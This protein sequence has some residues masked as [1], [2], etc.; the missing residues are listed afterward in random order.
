MEHIRAHQRVQRSVEQARR[1]DWCSQLPPLLHA[2][3]RSHHLS[4]HCPTPRPH[5]APLWHAAPAPRPVA[6]RLV[7]AP[8][9]PAASAS[10]PPR[11]CACAARPRSAAHPSISCARRCCS[12]RLA[13]ARRDARRSASPGTGLQLAAQQAMQRL[14]LEELLAAGCQLGLQR[15]RVK[16]SGL[17]MAML[18]L[19]I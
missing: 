8:A 11:R 19:R 14:K 18:H 9:V 2:G 13:A 5:P 1:R 12:S 15:L 7:A 4:S 10:C 6:R 16:A 17:G 3:K